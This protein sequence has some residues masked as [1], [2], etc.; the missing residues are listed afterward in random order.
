MFGTQP[1]RRP[2]DAKRSNELHDLNEFSDLTEMTE[3]NEFNELNDLDGGQ[4]GTFFPGNDS[5]GAP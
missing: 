2:C 3:F 5:L 1:K 4:V